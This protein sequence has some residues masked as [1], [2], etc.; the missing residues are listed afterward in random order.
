MND[1]LLLS[2]IRG[3]LIRLEETILFALIERAQFCINA[4]IYR[5]GEF[6]AAIGSDSLVGFLLYETECVHARMRRYTSPDE[7]PFYRNLPEPDLPALGFDENP[8]RPNRV[9]I[10]TVLRQAY[11]Q[12]IVPF[13]CKPGDD[14]QYGSSA[15][16]DVACL[17]ALSRRIHYG[18]F[19]AESK[20]RAHS[21]EFDALIAAGDVAALTAAIT[22]AAIE[23]RVLDRVTLKA[24][25]Y[26]QDLD[27]T[28]GDVKI[29]A[30]RVAQVYA[31]WIIPLT[32][33]VE[34]E[35]LQARGAAKCHLNG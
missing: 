4:R 2:S 16:C 23:K 32:K 14:S 30:A 35:Y 22:D 18:K 13:I 28:T 12:E 20:Y 11:E 29:D 15:V 25:T 27:G 10:N 7:H 24:Q 19:V 8:L 6:G 26:G 3:V 5:A 33:T 34:V 31:R 9:N 21:A 1:Q 17:Q